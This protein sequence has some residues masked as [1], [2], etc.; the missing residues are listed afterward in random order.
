MAAT[1][2][3]RVA[4]ALALASTVPRLAGAPAFAAPKDSDAAPELDVLLKK[5]AKS[6]GL[7]ARFREEKHLAMLDAPLVNEGTIHFAPPQR[8][9]R[10][11]ERPQE[12]T[13][14]IDGNKLQ[15][16][17]ADGH[18]SMDLGTNPVARLFVDSFTML[19]EG[20]RAGLERIFKLQFTP[21]PHG[22]WQLVL[23]PRVAPMDKMIKDLSLR[24]EGL[25]LR[26]MDLRETSGDSTHTV[27][28]AVDVE[29]RYGA[30]EL[31][32]VFR[33]PGK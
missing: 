5:F 8:L 18:E 31:A 27:F 28:T 19:L 29:H 17:D 32:R 20:N 26:D 24:G 4:L 33:L 30:A 11:T 1:A 14:L 9:A 6:P 22:A 16:G 3:A 7:F 12:S 15:F 25:T 13:L 23:V 2:R 21:R 10:H